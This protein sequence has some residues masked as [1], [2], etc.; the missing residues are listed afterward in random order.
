MVERMK[1]KARRRVLCVDD[2][3][4]TCEI[5]SIAWQNSYYELAL[6]HTY[7][8]ALTRALEGNFDVILLDSH[9]PDGSGIDLCQQIREADQQTP[10]IFYSADAMPKHIEKAMEA[11]ATTYLTKPLSPDGVEQEIEKL[12]D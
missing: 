5:M 8:E 12:L 6:A 11:G 7:A 3:T 9:L 10:I 1:E 2:D 4:D